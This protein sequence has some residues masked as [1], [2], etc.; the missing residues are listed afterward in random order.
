MGDHPDTLVLPVAACGIVLDIVAVG[1]DPLFYFHARGHEVRDV[2]SPRTDR[3]QILD[4]I[5]LAPIEPV[6][7]RLLHL[8]DAVRRQQ[9]VR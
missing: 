3:Q 2:V 8:P 9:G 5:A 7:E 4:L 6:C 1:G